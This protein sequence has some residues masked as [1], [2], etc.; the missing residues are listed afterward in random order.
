MHHLTGRRTQCDSKRDA[1]VELGPK[2][3]QGTDLTDPAGAQSHAQLSC[4]GVNMGEHR[5]A[6]NT[7]RKMCLASSVACAPSCLAC[8]GRSESRSAAPVLRGARSAPHPQ[9]TS[10]TAVSTGR[11]V[12]DHPPV[13]VHRLA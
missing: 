8:A 9:F 3:D 2:Q 5:Q 6:P 12:T 1:G 13:P 11:P 10:N 4:P 7:Q